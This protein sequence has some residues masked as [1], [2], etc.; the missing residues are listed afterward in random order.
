MTGRATRDD[1][2]MK[3]ARDQSEAGR[4]PRNK[5]ITIKRDPSNRPKKGESSG[6]ARGK[7]VER[8]AD[9]R[10]RRKDRMKE[11][12]GRDRGGDVGEGEDPARPSPRRAAK[13]RCS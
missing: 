9:G 8:R 11:G 1:A 2:Q 6:R 5:T 7:I 4:E 12:D 10:E 3:E 13:R